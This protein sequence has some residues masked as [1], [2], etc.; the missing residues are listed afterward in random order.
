MDEDEMDVLI[1]EGGRK[2]TR[3]NNKPKD[4]N[5]TIKEGNSKPDDSNNTPHNKSGNFLLAGPGGA[6][7]GQ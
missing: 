2:R 7:Q 4:G 3:T 1:M 5:D 6:R